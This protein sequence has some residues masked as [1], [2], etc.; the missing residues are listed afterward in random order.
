M[1][2][3]VFINWFITESRILLSIRT[4]AEG[5]EGAAPEGQSE[6]ARAL[7]GA[8]GTMGRFGDGPYRREFVFAGEVFE[9]ESGGLAL[10]RWHP[11]GLLPQ[12]TEQIP[13]VLLGI[14]NG[15][16]THALYIRNANWREPCTN[17]FKISSPMANVVLDEAEDPTVKLE[18]RRD[19]R[20]VLDG[21]EGGLDAEVLG[22]GRVAAG[23]LGESEQLWKAPGKK[24]V[25]GR[26]V[27]GLGALEEGRVRQA[28]QL[29]AGSGGEWTAVRALGRG[30]ESGLRVRGC[31]RLDVHCKLRVKGCQIGNIG[32]DS[33]EG[34]TAP[35][36]FEVQGRRQ[37]VEH[38]SLLAMNESV[39]HRVHD[40]REVWYLP[41]LWWKV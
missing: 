28:V 14:V 33:G 2:R 35:S 26:G 5:C 11:R 10:R 6:L 4:Q 1:R 36:H 16:N 18:A 31:F 38:L 27:T 24:S 29:G 37:A 15:W 12:E 34:G 7:C 20:Q 8:L 9:H 13:E 23:V 30:S 22:G 40:F 32:N 25:E 39:T 3:G 19:A 17:F 41:F 21:L